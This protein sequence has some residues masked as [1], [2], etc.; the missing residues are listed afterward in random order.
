MFGMHTG[1]KVAAALAAD[2]PDR[3][4]RLVLA[5]QTHSLTLEKDERNAGLGG[6]AAHHGEG[7]RQR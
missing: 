6:F 3:V 7:G 5:G 2:R 4:D 1:N